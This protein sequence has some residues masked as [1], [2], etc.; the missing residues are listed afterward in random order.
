MLFIWYILLQD[1]VYFIIHVEFKKNYTSSIKLFCCIV[2]TKIENTLEI[3]SGSDTSIAKLKDLIYEKKKRVF[4][5]E[6]DAC[7]LILW[8][9]DISAKNV[10]K[11]RTFEQL[12]DTNAENTI[13]EKLGKMLMP[14]YDIGEIFEQSSK[15]IPHKTVKTVMDMVLKGANT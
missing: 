3:T 13:I 10:D 1:R 7:D 5:N 15:N 12:L 6:F 2:G 8:K 4:E 9:V 11:L 14:L